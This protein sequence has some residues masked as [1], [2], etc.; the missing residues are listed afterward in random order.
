MGIIDFSKA[1]AGMVWKF[2]LWVVLLPLVNA[3]VL[4]FCIPSVWSTSGWK[5]TAV[6]VIIWA[7]ST[8]G[9]YFFGRFRSILHGL[10]YAFSQNTWIVDPIAAA[11]TKVLVK[12][13]KAESN[14]RIFTEK[15]RIEMGKQGFFK[16]LIYNFI[17]FNFPI[18][19]MMSEAVTQF[20]LKPEQ[21]ASLNQFFKNRI[22][23]I[24][25]DEYLDS[26]NWLAWVLF[27]LNLA[28]IVYLFQ[29]Y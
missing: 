11:V 4:A 25:R 19:E 9:Y 5:M 12:E 21:E 26:L 15:V 27:A 6:L 18:M 17:F 24:I 3:I 8:L 16:N 20:E 1:L 7:L 23:L 13:R 14:V 29:T 28:G 10:R 2:F 22:T